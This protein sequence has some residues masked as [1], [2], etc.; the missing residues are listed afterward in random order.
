MCDKMLK[1]C[2]SDAKGVKIMGRYK[3]LLSIF[4]VI[5]VL[6][7]CNKVPTQSVLNEYSTSEEET[8][9]TTPIQ[10]EENASTEDY[11]DEEDT[12]EYETG[13]EDILACQ[14]YNI[15]GGIQHKKGEDGIEKISFF[16]QSGEIPFTAGMMMFINGIPQSFTDDKGKSMYISRE[17]LDANDTIMKYYTCDYNNVPKAE[18]YI[19][20]KMCMLMP[21]TIV[22]KRKNFMMGFLQNLSN[23]GAHEIECEKFSEVDVVNLESSAICK[24]DDISSMKAL[25]GINGDMRTRTVIQRN[26]AKTYDMQ[27][28][29]RE[30]GEFVISF[31]GDNEP[32]QVGEHMYYRINC[33]QGKQYT[34]TFELEQDLV[35]S[36][37]NFFAVVCSTRDDYNWFAKTKTTIFVDLYE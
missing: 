17:K 34:Y 23:G 6:Y 7:G 33:E 14:N 25:H 13:P 29:P 1:H 5:S 37:D 28:I 24:V 22:V 30:T 16:V 26:D 31:W 35:N 21:D 27:V 15:G 12:E 19:C 8:P 10:N 3:R 2:N 36:V 18:T 11:M 32:V 20:R 4:L 9:T